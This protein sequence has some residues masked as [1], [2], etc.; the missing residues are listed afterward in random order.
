MRVGFAVGG[1]LAPIVFAYA[2]VVS[3]AIDETSFAQCAA[4]GDPTARL[5]CYDAL[6][7]RAP[8]PA[9]PA[10]AAVPAPPAPATAAPPAPVPA[11]FG[12]PATG[13]KEAE[14]M[15]ARVVGTLREWKRGTV[16]R[17]DNGQVWKVTGDETG[18]YPYVPENPEVTIKKGFFGGYYLQMEG[19]NSRIPV[20]RIS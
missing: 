17:L 14:A 6:A 18:Y 7:G 5:A 10:P 2:A 19:V 1:A 3:A 16:I 9:A 20:R 12:K 11:D 15:T 8:A 13:P 4:V